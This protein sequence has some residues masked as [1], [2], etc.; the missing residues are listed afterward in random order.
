M[1]RCSV[2]S[3]SLR[4][5]WTVALQAPL[6]RG[7]LQARILEWVAFPSPR[8]SSRPRD[9]TRV[10]YVPCIDRQTLYHEPHMGSRYRSTYRDT[11]TDLHIS[12]PP[13]SVSNKQ[14]P[15]EVPVWAGVG[16]RRQKHRHVDTDPRKHSGS[17]AVKFTPYRTPSL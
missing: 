10:S 13:R 16:A 1:P 9:G 11:N 2:V 17:T 14:F 15:D 3:D 4:P 8:G 7:I 6:S 12:Q 5:W